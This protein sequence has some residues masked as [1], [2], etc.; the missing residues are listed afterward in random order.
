MILPSKT[1]KEQRQLPPPSSAQQQYF[2]IIQKFL[3]RNN[4][5]YK[6]VHHGETFTSEESARARGVPLSTGGKALL[7]KLGDDNESRLS[8]FVMSASRKLNS[9]AIKKEM[10]RRGNAI[11]NIRFVTV[12]ELVEITGGLVPGCLP[13]FGKPILKSGIDGGVNSNEYEHDDAKFVE[14]YIDTSI[15]EENEVIAFNAGSL[16]DSIIM[17]VP[18]YLRVSDPNGIFDFSK[19]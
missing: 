7:L 19:V 15:A 17:S 2:K 9:K 11:K 13:P 4:V 10:K 3:D 18:D 1:T 14:L 5:T 16:T 6:T 8:L 12:E